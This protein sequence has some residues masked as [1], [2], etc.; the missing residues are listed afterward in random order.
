VLSPGVITLA[1]SRGV[2]GNPRGVGPRIFFAAQLFVTRL[3]LKTA[4]FFRAPTK[5]HLS[6]SLQAKSTRR[7]AKSAAQRDFGVFWMRSQNQQR[8]SHNLL[9]AQTDQRRELAQTFTLAAAGNS[10]L[11]VGGEPD[12]M[13]ARRRDD[14]VPYTRSNESSMG[15]EVVR[16][17]E[18]GA[19]HSGRPRSR[20]GRSIVLD[21]FFAPSYAQLL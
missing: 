2:T 3:N 6:V 15:P 16:A 11:L 10:G 9:R 14:S 18:E 19:A 4:A 21:C 12:R 5:N 7:R 17:D 20:R 13:A 1:G 8:V